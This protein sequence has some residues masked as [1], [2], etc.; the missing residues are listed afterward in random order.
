MGRVPGALPRH[1]RNSHGSAQVEDER[2][3]PAVKI[4]AAVA[5]GDGHS[6]GEGGAAYVC[7]FAVPFARDEFEVVFHHRVEKLGTVLHNIIPKEGETLKRRVK[8]DITILF[9]HDA[10]KWTIRRAG[11]R[12]EK[13]AMSLGL[14]FTGFFQAEVFVQMASQSHVEEYSTD[15]GVGLDN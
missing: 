10:S 8:L 14:V 4:G 2:D 12:H 6:E 5:E 15:F 3:S 7:V 9:R 13:A 1:R 11:V